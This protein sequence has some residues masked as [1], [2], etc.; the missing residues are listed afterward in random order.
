MVLTKMCYDR[1]NSLLYTIYI[2]LGNSNYVWKYYENSF[3]YK[4]ML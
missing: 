4:P 3:G 2:S 1:M